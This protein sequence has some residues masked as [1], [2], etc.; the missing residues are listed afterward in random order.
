VLCVALAVSWPPRFI[1]TSI[2]VLRPQSCCLTCA[3]CVAVA[4]SLEEQQEGI[5]QGSGVW[6]PAARPSGGWPVG[7]KQRAERGTHMHT[8]TQ[9]VCFVAAAGVMH[10]RRAEVAVLFVPLF[11]RSCPQP[12][13]VGRQP[14][15]AMCMPSGGVLGIRKQGRRAAC[16]S[17]FVRTLQAVCAASAT[18]FC[19]VMCVSGLC[20]MLCTVRACAE[21]TRAT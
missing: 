12:A 20:S 21:D 2:G 17:L 18:S 3:C 7:A 5:I 16:L 1:R 13:A 14:R 6:R 19:R 15:G 4:R 9:A 10:V 8:Y 11:A